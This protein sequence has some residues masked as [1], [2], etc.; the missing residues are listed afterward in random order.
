[1]NECEC[2]TSAWYICGL[3]AQIAV[4]LFGILVYWHYERRH[5][6]EY[7]ISQRGRRHKSTEI[8][9]IIKANPTSSV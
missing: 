3:V 1:M 9:S 5:F 6:Q 7:Y 4:T 2:V 8:K